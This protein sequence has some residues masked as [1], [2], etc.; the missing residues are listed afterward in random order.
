MSTERW[1]QQPFNWL[2]GGNYILRPLNEEALYVVSYQPRQECAPGISFFNSETRDGETALVDY[3]NGATFYILNGDFR[4][5]YESVIDGGFEAC[6]RVYKSNLDKRSSWS[7]DYTEVEE[8][9]K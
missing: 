8:A 6:L 1:E 3:K 5:E 4:K 2:G 9:I 7:S